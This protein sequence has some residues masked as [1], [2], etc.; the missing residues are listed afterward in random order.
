MDVQLREENANLK[1]ELLLAQKVID[2]K[3]EIINELRSQNDKLKSVL[4]MYD[5]PLAGNA[6]V[7][8]QKKPRT[9]RL[10]GISAEPESTLTQEE[11][12]QTK[13]TNYKKSDM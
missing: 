8:M 12:L 7:D 1:N 13:F 4:K 3:D 11:L 2:E 9:T 6:V 10:T 5:G